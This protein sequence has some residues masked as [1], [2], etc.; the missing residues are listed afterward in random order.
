MRKR[1]FYFNGEDTSA[2]Y[3][4]LEKK[5]CIPGAYMLPSYAEIRHSSKSGL[6]GGGV[7][8]LPIDDEI[9]LSLITKNRVRRIEETLCEGMYVFGH[10][11]PYGPSWS[12]IDDHVWIVEEKDGVPVIEK[13]HETRLLEHLRPGEK[14]P[15]RELLKTK[16]VIYHPQDGERVELE[17]LTQCKRHWD[18]KAGE[19]RWKPVRYPSW[20]VG[21]FHPEAKKE[22]RWEVDEKIH[23]TLNRLLRLGRVWEK[24]YRLDK[25]ML[26]THHFQED[27]YETPL[28]ET[29]AVSVGVSGWFK[30]GEGCFGIRPERSPDKVITFIELPVIKFADMLSGFEEGEYLPWISS[31]KEYSLYEFFSKGF[32]GVAEELQRELVLTVRK[33]V[34]HKIAEKRKE[35]GIATT[36]RT[37]KELMEANPEFLIGLDKFRYRDRNK[38]EYEQSCIPQSLRHYLNEPGDV[39]RDMLETWEFQTLV[40][41][42]LRKEQVALC[43]AIEPDALSEAENA[44]HGDWSRYFSR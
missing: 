38:R 41:E 32:K 40:K 1:S 26:A 6:S 28:E 19:Y 17:Y 30:F 11:E 5:I 25:T 3:S 12:E 15:E 7:I 10:Y 13:V 16:L 34:I 35:R 4:M 36:P 37:C 33:Y 2:W 43:R 27:P 24:W 29:E 23:P 21:L 39:S 18:G 14:T 22:L 42:Q 20:I 31:M 8:N 9:P 44:T